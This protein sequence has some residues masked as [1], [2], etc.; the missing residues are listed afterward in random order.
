[1]PAPHSSNHEPKSSIAETG[2]RGMEGAGTIFEASQEPAKGWLASF[3]V[4]EEKASGLRRR[5]VALPKGETDH[6]DYGAEAPLQ[7]VSCYL[8]TVISEVAT[9]FD[10]KAS[11]FQ[12]SLPQE[13]RAETP[14]LVELT[15]LPKGYGRRPEILCTVTRALAGGA[16][17]SQFEM[18]RAEVTENMRLDR[19][20]SNQWAAAGSG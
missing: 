2:A 10:L 3:T 12:A 19:Q 7:R 20:H 5:F 8:G 9:V 16:C 14:R 13:S 15:R 4:V 17:D 11:F 18:H 1:M 6:D